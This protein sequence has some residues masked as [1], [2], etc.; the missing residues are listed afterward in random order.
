MSNYFRLIPGTVPVATTYKQ[1]YF[2]KYNIAN[3]TL[4]TEMIKVKYIVLKCNQ[5]IGNQDDFDE[6]CE[7]LNG[8]ATYELS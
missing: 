3:T 6:H 4:T 1:A 8:M 5:A 7:L 2:D